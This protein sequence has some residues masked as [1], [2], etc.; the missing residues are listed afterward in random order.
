MVHKWRALK[1][2]DGGKFNLQV[3]AKKLRMSKKTLDDYYLQLCRAQFLKF[4]FFKYKNK[5]MGFLRRFVLMQFTEADKRSIKLSCQ[6]NLK[7]M[8]KLTIFASD[9]FQT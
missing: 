9:F 2:E 6:K 7:K 5:K 8:D 1:S 3:S 4:D